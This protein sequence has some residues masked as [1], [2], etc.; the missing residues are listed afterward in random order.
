MKF[1]AIFQRGVPKVR[2]IFRDANLQNIVFLEIR[3]K[4][5]KI[6]ITWNFKQENYHDFKRMISAIFTVDWEDFL[7]F[8]LL[9]IFVL[10][11][12]HGVDQEFS[13]HFIVWI[14]GD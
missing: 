9:T 13:A 12:L 8:Q 5:M 6:P 11:H 2:P 3:K 4:S 14:A 1:N 7:G 10:Q